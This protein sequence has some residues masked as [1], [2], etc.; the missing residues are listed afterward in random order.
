MTIDVQP[1]LIVGPPAADDETEA[2]TA[3]RDA[4]AAEA[5]S[6][7]EGFPVPGM[8]GGAILRAVARRRRARND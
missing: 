8:A 2:H 1:D 3:I 5:L 6:D 7:G 4:K